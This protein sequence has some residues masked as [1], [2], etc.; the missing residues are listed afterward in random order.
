[1]RLFLA[2]MMIA[3]AIVVPA[4]SELSPAAAQPLP[5]SGDNSILFVVDTSGS[6]SG[7]KLASAKAAIVATVG[8]LGDSYD[9]GLREFSGGC[10]NPG[11]LIIPVGPVDESQFLS[12]VNALTAGGGTPTTAALELAATELP[13]GGS[14]VLIADGDDQCGDLCVTAQSIASQGLNLTIHA[15]GV[16]VGSSTAADMQCAAAATGG[17]YID[18]TDL[19]DFVS[20]LVDITTCS[21][22]I[23]LCYAPEVRFHWDENFYPMDPTAFVQGSELW[24][25]ADVNCDPFRI[26][27]SPKSAN[28]GAGL[29]ESY[30]SDGSPGVDVYIDF[31]SGNFGVEYQ[32]CDPFEEGLAYRSDQFTRPYNEGPASNG[33][34]R[35]IKGNGSRL[36]D[37]EGFYLDWTGGAPASGVA[38]FADAEDGVGRA[39]EAP[40]FYEQTSDRI[41]YWMF[42]GHDPKANSSF[43]NTVPEALVDSALAHEG[44]WEH[45]DVILVDGKASE[46]RYYGH[47]C[48]SIDRPYATA[49]KV[50]THPVIYVAEGSHA[51]YPEEKIPQFPGFPWPDCGIFKGVTDFA[52]FDDSAGSV[53]WR[54]WKQSAFARPLENRSQCWYGF[55]GAWGE[56]GNFA[57]GRTHDTGPVGP[58]F[59]GTESGIDSTCGATIGNQDI[60]TPFDN[61][62]EWLQSF[63]LRFTGG[64]ANRQYVASIESVPTILGEATSD[65]A[66]NLRF[67]LVIPEG[68]APG[69]HRVLIQDAVTGQ[70]EF[71]QLLTVQI[72]AECLSADPTSGLDVDADRVLD[73][74][75]QR[76]D[77]GPAAD[78][79]GDSVANIVDNCPTI[80]N[81][82]QATSSASRTV[83]IACD[84]RVGVNTIATHIALGTPPPTAVPTATEFCVG[85]TTPVDDSLPNGG[86]PTPTEFCP[87]STTPVDDALANGGCPVPTPEPTPTPAVSPT[88]AP[89]A[90]PTPTFEAGPADLDL[91]TIDLVDPYMCGAGFAG[92]VTGGTAPYQLSYVISGTAGTFDLGA[93]TVVAA[94]SYGSPPGYIDYSVVPDGAYDVAI[95]V[96]DSSVPPKDL[97]LD[98]AFVAQVTELCTVA[99]RPTPDPQPT[100]VAAPIAMPTA[101]FVPTYPTAVFVPTYPTSVFVPASPVTTGH[102][103]TAGAQPS[104]ISSVSTPQPNAATPHALALTGA[105]PGLATMAL[106]MIALGALLYSAGRLRRRDDRSGGGVQP[107]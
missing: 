1:M 85:T 11:D 34:L 66:G 100:V 87:G 71:V 95:A 74:C 94:G 9:M 49:E 72:P 52:A 54:T 41:T 8:E 21:V 23:V 4:A 83:G 91:D 40:I 101:V 90:T 59:A 5:T 65:G 96:T 70:T 30:E 92:V 63:L 76:L 31:W 16:Q 32:R 37:T 50:G 19:D 39:I 29:Y 3:S 99:G 14:I 102:L 97:L 36:E 107:R 104:A 22:D 43:D 20:T 15:V 64:A 86:C 61:L 88:A 89:A 42:Y 6:M 7:S 38:P 98:P 27:A 25:A 26:S 82:D 106:W 10:S 57:F 55:G 103:V 24:W 53:T 77:D 69:Q 45:I 78:Y 81:S 67:E 33:A 2:L 35:P 13:S 51:S 44:D 17:D 58:P 75:D 62:M 56:T 47:G 18:V 79:D 80:P 46:V 73:T 48:P 12:E 84:E 93:F 28:L 68:T 105:R 60:T